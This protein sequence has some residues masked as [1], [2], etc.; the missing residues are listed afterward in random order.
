MLLF[1]C[2]HSSPLL[3]PSEYRTSSF[4]MRSNFLSGTVRYEAGSCSRTGNVIGDCVFESVKFSDGVIIIDKANGEY[5]IERSAFIHN[6][7][8]PLVGSNIYL[9]KCK[10]FTGL[11]LCFEDVAA[12]AT[13]IFAAGG[14]DI[15]EFSVNHTVTNY[16]NGGHSYI[17]GGNTHLTFCNHNQSFVT[18]V[19][20]LSIWWHPIP[21][22]GECVKY[23]HVA[24]SEGP[25]VVGANIWVGRSTISMSYANIVNSTAKRFLQ[26]DTDDY[27]TV[28]NSIILSVPADNSRTTFTDCYL[29][30]PHVEYTLVSFGVNQDR[31]CIHSTYEFT[32]LR[33]GKVR[34]TVAMLI[35]FLSWF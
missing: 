26:D 23:I 1:L 32:S 13:S 3:A 7:G 2:L 11:S 29:Y 9:V 31:K 17:Y 27:L 19:F 20:S 28:Y 34:I 16:G 4:S 24:S 5:E 25:G 22:S 14:H 33:D 21:S 18:G 8:D 15:G 12:R 35:L 6:I 10:R 30:D